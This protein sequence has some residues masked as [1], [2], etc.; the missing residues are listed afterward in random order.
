MK[1]KKF[2]VLGLCA[3]GASA[4]GFA[5]CSDGVSDY[6]DGMRTAANSAVTVD[7]EIKLSD[8]GVTVYTFRRH[9]EID[10]EAHTATVTDTKITLS[11]NFEEASAVSTSSVENV[12]GK[13]LIGLKLSKKLVSNYGISDGDLSCTVPKNKISEVLTKSVSASSDMTLTV[14]MQDGNLNT[15]E[16]TYVNSSSRTVS[17]T[18]TYGY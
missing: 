9:M 10:T 13:S 4:I 17:V 18:V 1:I 7:A 15:V 5:A 8:S 3:L 16:Y 6:V 2:L 12:T 14:D 11:D